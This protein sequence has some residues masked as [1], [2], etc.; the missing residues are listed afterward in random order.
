MKQQIISAL[1]KALGEL[2]VSGVEPVVEAPGESS[3]GDY[4][5][6][7]ALNL[8][9]QIVNLKS[10]TQKL[11]PGKSPIELAQQIVKILN[12]KYQILNTDRIEAVVPGFINF[13]LSKEFLISQ[14]SKEAT[15]LRPSSSVG[16][17]VMVEFTDPN[18][19][20]EFHIG[21]LYSN[22]VGESLCR[23]LEAEGAE[24]K[25]AN[26]QGDVGMH[27]A[28]ALYALLQIS[29]LSSKGGSAS[30][31]KS[32]TSNVQKQDV[33]TR[34]EF[35]GEAYALGAKAYEEDEAAKKEI[36]ELNKK[37]Y[38]KDPDVMGVYNKGRQWSLDYFESIYKRL[39][40]KFDFYYF[41]S[42]V[43]E[44]GLK[45]VK[46]Y[47]EKGV[48]EESEGAVI[49]PGK[50]FG[51]HTRVFIN[52]LGLPTY[53]AKELGLA[54]T[55]YQDFAYDQ[56][57][58][59]TGNEIIEYFK[60]LL[61]ALAKIRPDLALKT[62]HIPHGMV[63]L[64]QGKM[65]SRTG[66]II[67]GPWLLD[68]AKAK[69]KEKFGDITEEVAEQVAVGAVK[70]ALLKSSIGKDIAFSFEES[71][72]LEGNSGPYI[73]YTYA[74]TQ[75]VLAKVKTPHF[76]PLSGASR[77]KQ[78]SKVNKLNSEELTLL[79]LLHHFP[80][81]V[82]EASQNFAPNLLCNY[83]FNLAQ[84]FNLFY[85]KHQVIGSQQ[86]AFRLALTSA[87]GQTLNNGL[88]LLGIQAPE[89]M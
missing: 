89:R 73:Q 37:I 19:F 25:R 3:H 10:A 47:L 49:F 85:Q 67:T 84:S 34:V 18:P 30:G 11:K 79:R 20:K 82:G 1:K 74:R 6:N 9:S 35:L 72:N 41:E 61:S 86:E 32:Q 5:T 22:I 13:W 42:E 29:N 77:G 50:Q 33:K 88:Y 60:V 83:L 81:V 65:S 21:H 39:G 71:I 66:N 36:N 80:E 68:E 8:K 57:L 17:K 4:S 45:L 46:E 12:T 70:Y 54:P 69:I 40:T 63:R 53:E 52:S 15:P 51:L 62:K 44:I 48:F 2:G 78:N 58:I 59:I 27:I 87:V 26:Y 24:V 16:S 14:L 38:E 64:A 23:L 43:G 28:K 55:K 76:A 7:V 75:S 31:G 56:S